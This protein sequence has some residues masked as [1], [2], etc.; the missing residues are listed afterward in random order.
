MNIKS[1]V[2]QIIGPAAAGSAGPVPTTVRELP[3]FVSGVGGGAVRVTG[4][5]TGTCRPCQW[6]DEGSSRP[7]HKQ[8]SAHIF[9]RMVAQDLKVK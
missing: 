1:L 3:Q 8:R 2:R 6:R 9:F 7:R 5:V 4:H